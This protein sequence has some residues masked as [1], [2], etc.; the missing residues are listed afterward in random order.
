L[1]VAVQQ[2]LPTE[3]ILRRKKSGAITTYAQNN[4]VQD[5]TNLNGFRKEYNF[6]N[7]GVLK[8]IHART[9]AEASRS[10]NDPRGV[11]ILNL[12]SLA[13]P[14][15]IDGQASNNSTYPRGSL[16]VTQLGCSMPIR[17]LGTSTTTTTLRFIRALG[18]C[19]TIP[20]NGCPFFVAGIFRY[21]VFSMRCVIPSL[22]I[23]AT[24]YQ[25]GR[26]TSSALSLA[27]YT[28]SSPIICLS[29]RQGK[30]S[31]PY[32]ASAMR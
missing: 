21:C 24:R 15:G 2:C 32:Q 25:V 31:C 19:V 11:E 13:E 26:I 6:D 12:V 20:E 28:Q 7:V 29:T 14:Y 30:R 17:K 18:I 27:P 8:T 9:A 4:Q 5:C 10:R 1:F 23:C 16:C 3:D 22:L